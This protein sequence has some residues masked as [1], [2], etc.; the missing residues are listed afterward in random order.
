MFEAVIADKVGTLGALPSTWTTKNIDYG[1]VVWREGGRVLAWA[2]ELEVIH[3]RWEGRHG[4]RKASVVEKSVS[5]SVHL[6]GILSSLLIPGFLG[7][8]GSILD[9]KN[10][11]GCACAEDED[12]GPNSKALGG[13]ARGSRSARNVRSSR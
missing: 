11:C 9:H 2:G 4:G 10:V 8:V 7:S 13:M 12:E 1:D 5:L 6:A 3:G